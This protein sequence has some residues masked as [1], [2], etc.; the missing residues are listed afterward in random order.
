MQ[1]VPLLMKIIVSPVPFVNKLAYRTKVASP[2]IFM[3]RQ[4]FLQKAPFMSCSELSLFLI[5]GAYHTVMPVFSYLRQVFISRRALFFQYLH[6]LLACYG[7]FL[8][9]EPCQLIQ[10]FS[11]CFYD[12]Y[13]FRVLFLHKF[14][15]LSVDLALCLLGT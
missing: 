10:L 14:D 1:S 2:Y 8:V 15:H 4:H 11:V 3:W 6:E 5:K 12:I 13:G 9:K 7:L